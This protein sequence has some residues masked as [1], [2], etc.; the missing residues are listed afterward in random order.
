MDR[1]NVDG[2]RAGLVRYIT[3]RWP[4][5]CEPASESPT[6]TQY[7]V[8]AVRRALVLAETL[9]GGAVLADEHRGV[10]PAARE[11]LRVL[12]GEEADAGPG[13]AIVET[14]GP[15]PVAALDR[16]HVQD[17]IAAALDAS[18]GRCARCKSFLVIPGV[19]YPR[20]ELESALLAA[21]PLIRA[22]ERERI[23]AR[24]DELA[25]NYPEDVF[26]PDS[27]VRD[28]IGGT[29]MRHAYRNAAREVREADHG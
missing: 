10:I 2:M 26:P 14:M 18:R 1:G 15:L 7:A 16:E 11:A 13:E 29:A 27:D 8:E 21:A 5:A 25:A 4:H 9:C 3:E 23:A 12:S 24:M 19:T 22:A 6:A 17:L 20:D 28:A